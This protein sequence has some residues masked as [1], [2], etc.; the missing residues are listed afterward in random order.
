[1]R[2]L[3]SGNINM[4][5]KSMTDRYFTCDWLVECLSED[6]LNHA[7]S[8]AEDTNCSYLVS[9]RET[10]GQD[11]RY[12]VPWII[13][14][15]SPEAFEAFQTKLRPFV[16]FLRYA[17]THETDYKE[18]LLAMASGAP[19]RSAAL[20]EMCQV[21]EAISQGTPMWC[22]CKWVIEPLTPSIL[23]KVFNI[24]DTWNCKIYYQGPE[25]KEL[26]KVAPNYY[27]HFL[28]QFAPVARLEEF[29]EQL[30]LYV[31]IEFWTWLYK[32]PSNFSS[33]TLDRYGFES[34]AMLTRENATEFLEM[35][36]KYGHHN[37]V[38][39]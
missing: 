8:L 31:N 17:P 35:T 7:K 9:Y 25:P 21:N 23:S 34:A 32:R 16:S 37:K 3:G 19:S 22:S 29:I 38:S 1:M 12:I 26:T 5:A 13:R 36:H 39:R 33:S 14:A 6:V 24:L 15:S 4:E 11:G 30:S 10:R 20:E 27:L 18:I 2:H 28:V